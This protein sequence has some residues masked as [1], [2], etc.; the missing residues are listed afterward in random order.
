MCILL[1]VIGISSLSS[2]E[3]SPADTI[4]VKRIEIPDD[5]IIDN[6]NY[7]IR[8]NVFHITYDLIA[9]PDKGP[10]EIVIKATEESIRGRTRFTRVITPRT[11][12]GDIGR[13]V[14]PGRGKTIIWQYLQDIPPGVYTENIKLAI[15]VEVMERPVRRKFPG[16]FVGILTTA[17]IG[18][19]AAYFFLN[20]EK[21]E[22][23]LGDFPGRPGN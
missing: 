8:E 12:S 1:I 15:E 2:Q 20:R 5:Y 19:G 10:F 17:V 9:H 13:G 21:D 4:Q 14:K 23:G 6:L 22:P 16:V 7:S 3:N 11:L 18:S